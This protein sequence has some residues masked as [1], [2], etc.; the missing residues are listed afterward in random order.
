MRVDIYCCVVMCLLYYL[1][2]IENC[3]S[4]FFCCIL[5]IFIVFLLFNIFKNVEGGKV[6]LKCFGLLIL[7]LFI[8]FMC[9]D[10]S[11]CIRSN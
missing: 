4:N 5:I 11:K 8:V 6:F 9:K 1:R 2:L 7:L 3:L 10:F